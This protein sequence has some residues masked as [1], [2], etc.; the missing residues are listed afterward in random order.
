MKRIRF[1][2]LLFAA[3]ILS[4]CE[5]LQP[6][7]APTDAPPAAVE[8]TNEATT[9]PAPEETAVVAEDEPET[10]PT[11]TAPPATEA[12]VGPTPAG[13]ALPAAEIDND[14]GGPAVVNGD[15]NYNLGLYQPDFP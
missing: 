11:A 8:T 15:W 14:E 12:P 6:E 4:A 13:E 5:S 1:I 2:S 3:L 10:A 7:T 9:E